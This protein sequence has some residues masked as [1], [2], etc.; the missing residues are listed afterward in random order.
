MQ[1]FYAGA[2]PRKLSKVISH[3]AQPPDKDTS[4]SSTK[5]R[6]KNYTRDLRMAI[7]DALFKK[8]DTLMRMFVFSEKAK[9]QNAIESINWEDKFQ[10][11]VYG[12][13]EQLWKDLMTEKK[14]RRNEREDLQHTLF[15]SL[16]PRLHCLQ[17][18]RARGIS[19]CTCQRRETLA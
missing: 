12:E 5:Y 19:R 13:L 8:N 10:P 11:L 17:L 16:R 4:E 18:R 7:L 9:L 15:L 2:N 6:A 3:N 1:V 14:V